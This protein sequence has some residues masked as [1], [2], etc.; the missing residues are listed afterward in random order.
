M[1][2]GPGAYSPLKG[3]QGPASSISVVLELGSWGGRAWPPL[4]ISLTCPHMVLPSPLAIIDTPPNL[5]A[6]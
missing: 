1:H 6:H 5:S 4:L 3:T 2:R